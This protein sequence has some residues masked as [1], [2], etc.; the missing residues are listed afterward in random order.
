MVDIRRFYD[1]HDL[2]EAQFFLAFRSYRKGERR[3]KDS[4]SG[5]FILC[6]VAHSVA[7]RMDYRTQDS[8]PGRWEDLMVTGCKRAL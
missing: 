7:I 1:F 3:R 2:V 6:R 8:L 5:R 4:L